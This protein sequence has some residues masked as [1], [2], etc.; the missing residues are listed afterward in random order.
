MFSA[1]CLVS[2]LSKHHC[3]E[4]FLWCSDTCLSCKKLF[5]AA[6]WYLRSKIATV[7]L[8]PSGFLLQ[9]WINPGDWIATFSGLDKCLQNRVSYLERWDFHKNI[10]GLSEYKL[11]WPK[12]LEAAFLIGSCSIKKKHID[13]NCWKVQGSHCVKDGKLGKT[14]LLK[15]QKKKFP[16]PVDDR[17]P[18]FCSFLQLFK[19]LG[20]IFQ[21]MEFN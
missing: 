20:L 13:S 6:L 3:L 14:L 16:M 2:R 15:W 7:L 5:W 12:S 4:N 17:R 9:F 19:R 1:C 10:L 8:Q 11:S 21:R 18:V